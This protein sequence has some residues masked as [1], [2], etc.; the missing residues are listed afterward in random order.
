M[1]QKQALIRLLS[2]I[3]E[4]SKS[5]VKYVSDHVSLIVISQQLDVDEKN[6]DA[7]L[8]EDKELEHF[9]IVEQASM[10]GCV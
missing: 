1:R 5:F 10:H 8:W 3:N 4:A 9:S 7:V 6:S 2:T